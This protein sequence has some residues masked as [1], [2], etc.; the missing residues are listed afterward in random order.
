MT[1]LEDVARHVGVTTATVSNVITGKGSV[2]EKTRARVFAAVEE[3][4]YQP[5]L[6]ARGLAR[7]KTFTLALVLLTIANSFYAEIAEEIESIARQHGYQLLLCITHKDARIGREHLKALSSRWVDGLLVMG[8]SLPAVDIQTRRGHD[9][10][11]MVLC[12]RSEE[13][14]SVSVPVVD[15]D[16]RHAGELAAQHLLE[17]GHRTFAVIVE[18]PSHIL[19]LEG[20]RS[21]LTASGIAL[22]KAYIQTGD[23]SMQSGYDAT[24]TLLSRPERPTAIFATN[25]LMALG[26]VEAAIDH[27]LRV[28]EDLSVIGLDDIM[29]GRHVRPPL[30]TVAIPKQELARQ[31]IELLLRYIDDPEAEPELLTVRP[32]LVI[33]RSTGRPGAV[34]GA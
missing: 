7:R 8:G 2:S 12:I 23:S 10:Q 24:R 16:F 4:G 22:P 21:T 6:V 9:K 26:A 34:S 13:E 32:H 15:I 18:A 25:D 11:P 19:R 33:R 31:A 3:L 1:T 17:L 20:F 27:G 28:P 29:L 30:T 5:N 14:Q